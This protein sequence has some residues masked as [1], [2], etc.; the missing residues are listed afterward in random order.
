MI[1]G[2]GA[3]PVYFSPPV[4]FV[5]GAKIYFAII[6]Y[7]PMAVQATFPLV[8][9]TASQYAVAFRFP[10]EVSLARIST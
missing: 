1:P 8:G 10:R 7:V 4:R 5:P 6:A 2:L 3:G 9:T